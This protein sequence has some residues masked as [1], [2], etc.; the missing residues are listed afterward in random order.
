MCCVCLHVAPQPFLLDN[1]LMRSSYLRELA[2][3]SKNPEDKVGYGVDLCNAD[4]S[5]PAIN[6]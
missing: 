1:G 5:W 3:S 2:H 6:W 4:V